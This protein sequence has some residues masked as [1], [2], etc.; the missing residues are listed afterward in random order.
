MLHLI[1]QY[2][3]KCGPRKPPPTH[4]KNI[5]VPRTIFWRSA[6]GNAPYNV[7]VK[8]RVIK[9]DCRG[10]NKLSYTIHLR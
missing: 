1:N 5:W 3:T 8:N 9:N 6:Q 10:F 4:P 2:Q 7:T